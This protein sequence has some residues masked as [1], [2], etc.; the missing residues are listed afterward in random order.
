MSINAICE[1]LG[2]KSLQLLGMHYLT[3]SDTTSYFQRKGKPSDLKTLVKGDFEGLDT[4]LGEFGASHT[5]LISIR[6]AFICTLYGFPVGTS[7]AEAR[8]QYK[9]TK[10]PLNSWL[11]QHMQTSLLHIN[12]AHPVILSKLDNK[13]QHLDSVSECLVGRSKMGSQFQRLQKNRLDQRT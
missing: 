9:N 3:G 13:K 11:C 7:V 12:K 10:S 6:E 2:S 1:K 4:A 8:H 5:D